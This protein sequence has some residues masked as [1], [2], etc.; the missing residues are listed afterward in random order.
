MDTTIHFL[1]HIIQNLYNFIKTI[2]I[3]DIMI[4]LLKFLNPLINFPKN[5]RFIFVLEY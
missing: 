3:L 1:L 5:I 4:N 2:L